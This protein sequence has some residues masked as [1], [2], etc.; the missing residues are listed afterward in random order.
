[1]NKNLHISL[2]C[3]VL[4]VVGC[5]MAPTY[6]RPVAPIPHAWP[7][8]EVYQ[9]NR[10]ATN[11]PAAQDLNWRKFFTDQKLRQVI[12]MAL[13]NNLDLRLAAQ[14]VVEARAKY[15]IQRSELLPVVN[16][17]ADRIRERVPTDLSAIGRPYTASEYDASLGVASWE[18]DFFG[19]IR[20]L[21]NVA[22]QEYFATEQGCRSAQVSLISSVAGVYLTLAAD[23]QNLTIAENTLATQQDSY[24][25][26]KHR[27]DLEL[28]NDLVL[29][30]A[31]TQVDAARRDV[32]TYKQIVALDGN[33]LN[34]L[35]G[36]SV[37]ERLLPA[38]LDDIAPP[39]AVSAGL[40]SEVLL[41]RPDVLQAEAMLKAANADIGAARADFFPR[42]SLTAAIGASSGE[43]SDL[44]KSAS[45][46][47]S[48]APQIVLP[49]FDTRTWFALKASK[50]QRDLAV[51]EY[52]KTIQG[53]FRDVADA[54]AIHGTVGQQ[55][56]AQQS[57]VDAS[58]ETYR[59]SSSRYEKG[60][61]SYLSVLDAQR[62]L[63]A[64]Q[65]GLVSLRRA[66]L[67]SQV[68]LYAV[69]GG[70]WQPESASSPTAGS[71]AEH[72]SK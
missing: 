59:L 44:F 52:Q 58:A 67:V 13:T 28:V 40:P 2:L 34:L 45:G 29:Q 56:S 60:I 63:F 41:T 10:T 31:Q 25:L 16:G 33:A 27:H 17:S 57:L 69:L 24:N 19:R 62:S 53:A 36:F 64:A 42:I 51:T 55:V 71:L 22:L 14:N 1:M 37:P 23:R 3:V 6:T 18:I 54:L 7:S 5:T 30:Q 38:S 11:A 32:V 46:A 70:G 20:S 12:G 68:N 39:M 65:Q 35:A 47:W 8:G 61:D 43:L 72:S 48:Y 15:G 50:A 9:A 66:K 4:A 49:V 26:I 21:K